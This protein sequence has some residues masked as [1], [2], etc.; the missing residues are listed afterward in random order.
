MLP[1]DTVYGL[2]CSAPDQAA[3]QRLYELK[4][5]REI[6]PTALMAASVEVILACI[7]E[8]EGRWVAIA[9]ALL[10]GPLTLVLPN[11]ARRFAWLT[12]DRKDTIGV[13][14]PA[15]TAG[16]KA[17]LDAAGA[18]V[19]T[20]ANLS[21][22]PDPRT[23]AQVPLE[24]LRGV[25]AAIDGG[26]LPGTPSTVLDITGAAPVVLREGALS[27]V[28][29]LRLLAEATASHHTILTP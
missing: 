15:L 20:S 8:L 1:T 11:P 14:V 13:R 10:P 19:A 26:E 21:G 29:T 17:M 28:E 2:A 9:Y 23:L 22:G 18:I 25:A 3:A 12:G 7:P 5:R 27:A 24:I 16:S 6:Q 4:G